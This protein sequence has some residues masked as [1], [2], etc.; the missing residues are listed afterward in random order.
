MK[1]DKG[2]DWLFKHARKAGPD[3][4]EYKNSLIFN[5]IENVNDLFIYKIES[6]T[7]Y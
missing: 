2:Y 3:T 4:H 5:N 7:I 1:K 6:L